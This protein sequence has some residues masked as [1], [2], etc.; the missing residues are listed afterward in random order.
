[1]AKYKEQFNF[2]D[3][4]FALFVHFHS[5]CLILLILFEFVA[6][7]ST[8]AGCNTVASLRCQFG[9]Q[10]IQYASASGVCAP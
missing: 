10:I 9:V 2:I 5:S 7:S 1:M 8:G 3:T 4:F 6:S